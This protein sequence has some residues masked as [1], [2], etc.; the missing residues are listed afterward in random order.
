VQATEAD[1]TRFDYAIFDQDQLITNALLTPQEVEAMERDGLRCVRVRDEPGE[2]LPRF[3]G[4]SS[5][6]RE[7]PFARRWRRD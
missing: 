7:A 5:V 1:V 4:R 3:R 2:G 6:I